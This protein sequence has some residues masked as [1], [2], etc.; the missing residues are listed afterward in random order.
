MT[1][2]MITKHSECLEKLEKYDA[3]GCNYLSQPH[4]H[5][6]GNFWWANSDYLSNLNT[7]KLVARHDAEWWVLSKTDNFYSIFNSNINHYTTE[8]PKSQY[9]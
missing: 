3:I 6:S 9:T 1:Y 4:P 8:Y 7:D 2:F 5:F